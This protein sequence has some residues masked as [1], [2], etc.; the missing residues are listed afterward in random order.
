MGKRNKRGGKEERKGTGGTGEVGSREGFG[1]KRIW[2]GSR[3][4]GKGR[5]EKG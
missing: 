1:R 2:R 3:E 5:G 4:N